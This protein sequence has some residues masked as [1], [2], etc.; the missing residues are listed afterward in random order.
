MCADS[1]CGRGVG[2]CSGSPFSLLLK[3]QR[4]VPLGPRGALQIPITFAPHEMRSYQQRCTVSMRREDG[5]TW[6]AAY[7]SAEHHCMDQN[8]SACLRSPAVSQFQ[9][10][11]FDGVEARTEQIFLENNLLGSWFCSVSE[12]DSPLYF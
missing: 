12:E 1:E 3:S 7:S 8:G 4:N 2:Q 11:S 6:D 10:G 9:T 5:L